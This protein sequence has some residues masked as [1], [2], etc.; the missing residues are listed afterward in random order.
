[1]GLETS[2]G[3]SPLVLVL[4]LAFENLRKAKAE[5]EIPILNPATPSYQ[6]VLNIA[7]RKIR[8]LN[9]WPRKLED[10]KNSPN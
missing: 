7:H 1:M 3:V 4:F 8:A 6:S 5:K 2:L 10:I 9:A